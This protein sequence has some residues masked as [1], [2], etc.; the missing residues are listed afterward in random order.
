MTQYTSV[1]FVYLDGHNEGK[2]MDRDMTHMK[3]QHYCL[4]G[5]RG[6]GR[7]SEMGIHLPSTNLLQPRCIH[8]E[9]YIER[10]GYRPYVEFKGDFSVSLVLLNDHNLTRNAISMNANK[11]IVVAMRSWR[12]TVGTWWCSV[13]DYYRFSCLQEI[14]KVDLSETG[15]W[16]SLYRIQWRLWEK[17]LTNINKIWM[18][19]FQ[20]LC[21]SKY[22]FSSQE[23]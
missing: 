8:S 11:R 1:P 5:E 4:L 17:N 20:P 7:R 21:F 15:T 13:Y 3:W 12:T 22:E 19:C 10:S 14:H 18:W 16:R 6:G 2:R 9:K 23:Q